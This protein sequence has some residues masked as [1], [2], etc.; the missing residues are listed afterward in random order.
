[1]QVSSWLAEELYDLI[2]KTFSDISRSRVRD[3]IN[4]KRVHEVYV[5]PGR[6]SSRIIGDNKRSERVVLAVPEFSAE[7]WNIVLEEI[8]RSPFAASHIYNNMLPHAVSDSLKRSGISLLPKSDEYSLYVDDR[9]IDF[10]FP[11]TGADSDSSYDDTGIGL[12]GMDIPVY[13]L[14][15]LE[16]FAELLLTAPLSI[17]TL[18]GKNVETIVHS[19]RELRAV[20][21]A[22]KADIGHAHST[23]DQSRRTKNVSIEE[24]YFGKSI[25]ELFQIQVRADELPASVLR[26][27]DPLPIEHPEID[28]DINL[29][30]AYGRVTRLAQSLARFLPQEFKQD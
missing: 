3:L 15:I 29:E 10:K 8:S 18:R 7:I 11:E 17:C 4:D 1:M 23:F 27:I 30:G 20:N 16:K 22:G 28:M 21:I 25:E 19:V 6:V 9:L 2:Q 26:R 14:A 12:D 5:E 24:Y 13:V